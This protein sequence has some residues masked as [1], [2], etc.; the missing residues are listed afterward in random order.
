M[1]PNEDKISQ[2][3]LMHA[4]EAALGRADRQR[5][6]VAGQTAITTGERDL[7]VVNSLDVELTGVRAEVAPNGDDL[8]LPRKDLLVNLKF[9]LRRVSGQTLT[10]ERGPGDG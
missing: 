1:P 5:Q 7:W 2:T 3:E 6:S 8:L 4:F 10:G 9:G